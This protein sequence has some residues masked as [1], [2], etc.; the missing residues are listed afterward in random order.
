MLLIN[1]CLF[2]ILVSLLRLDFVKV[3]SLLFYP[4]KYEIQKSK[5]FHDFIKCLTLFLSLEKYCIVLL[6]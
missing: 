4:S 6:L 2:K 3:L 1:N 5:S